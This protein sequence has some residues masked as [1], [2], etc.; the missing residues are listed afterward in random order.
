M[1]ASFDIA[2]DKLLQWEGGKVDDPVD[3]GGRT[4]Y[5]VTQWSWNAYT[6]VPFDVWEI[7]KDQAKQFYEDVYWEPMQLQR[8]AAQ[9]LADT[10][11]SFGANQGKRTALRRL[12]GL[13]GVTQD[14]IMGK[15]TW[16]RL[17]VAN[18]EVLNGLFLNKTLEFYNRLIER[19]PALVKFEKGW[20]NRINAYRIIKGVV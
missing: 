16:E 14:G 12:Q 3:P 2:F 17:S 6:G 8:I 5:G 15:K 11:L 4:N 7:T 19:N 18:Q 1:T 13:L 9:G 10:L 20:K